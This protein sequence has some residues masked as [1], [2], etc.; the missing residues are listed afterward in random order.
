MISVDTNHRL[1]IKLWLSDLEAN[2]ME[3]AA[4]LA[5]LPFAVSHI[6]IMPDSHLGYGMPIGAILAT[7]HVVVPNAVG[8]DIG[9]GMSAFKTSL[10]A[11]ALLQDDRTPLKQILTTIRHTIP[12]GNPGRHAEPQDENYMPHFPDIEAWGGPY[13]PVLHGFDAALQQ[14][15]TLGGG[16]HFI[17]IQAD[18]NNDVWI[19]VHSGSRNLG[20]TT[21]SHHDKIAQKLNAQWHSSVPKGW[22]L[23]FLPTDSDAGALYLR[24]MDYCVRFATHNRHLMTQRIVEALYETCSIPAV[25]FEEATLRAYLDMP[26]NYAAMENHFGKNVMV[27]RKGAIRARIGERGIIPGS[28]GAPS[29]IVQGKGNEQSFQSAS[30]GAGRRMGRKQAQRELNLQDEQA[31]LDALGTLHAVRGVSDLDEAPSAYKDIATVMANQ[32]DLVEIE[33][34]LRP[35][36]TIKAGG[37]PDY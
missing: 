28:Q 2:A 13:S 30:H 10:Q 37:G 32:E 18:H 1:P 27:H 11:D 31:Q 15:G 17:E 9:C 19:M 33:Y 3:Q 7:E 8:V 34:T 16:N 26:H 20:H 24:E 22:Q 12:V 5:D 29:Y 21:A 4:H 14:V 23:A 6:P 35:L 25:P 36:A